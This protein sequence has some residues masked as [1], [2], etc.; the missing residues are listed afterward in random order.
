MRSSEPLPGTLV[1]TPR[2]F[3]DFLVSQMFTVAQN[4]LSSAPSPSELARA[5]PATGAAPW[6]FSDATDGFSATTTP[7]GRTGALSA[8]GGS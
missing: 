5:M 1:R 6:P 2:A 4:G 3:G 7:G 8:P